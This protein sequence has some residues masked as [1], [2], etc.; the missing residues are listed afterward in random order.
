MDSGATCTKI[1]G[2]LL[3]CG[4]EKEQ[5]VLFRTVFYFHQNV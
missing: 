1:T 4:S 2:F 3:I 5:N